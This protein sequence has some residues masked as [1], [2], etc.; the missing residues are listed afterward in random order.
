VLVWCVIAAANGC[1]SVHR[2]SF[3]LSA[4]TREWPSALAVAHDQALTG[5]FGAADS[6]LADF[7]TRYPGTP[8]ALETA[9]WRA[10]FNLDPTNALGSLPTAMAS[11]DAYLGDSRPR[12]H[13]TEAT[14]VRRLAGEVDALN[15]AAAN[16]AAQARDATQTAANA[17]AQASDANARAEA[18]KSDAAGSNDAEVKH[19]RD[20]LAKA[21]SELDRIKK[22]LTQ[23]PPK[24]PPPV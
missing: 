9:Y 20:E 23:T 21:N 2:P 10:L 3:A 14:V 1:V 15:S 16:A 11:L 13:V 22:R 7:A 8:E 6:T 24:T 5:K 19:L 18:A 12:E 17:K 4:P